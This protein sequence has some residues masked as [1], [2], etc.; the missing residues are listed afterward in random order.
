MGYCA[1]NSRV[2]SL[3][4]RLFEVFQKFFR[5]TLAKRDYSESDFN[6][7]EAFCAC[8]SADAIRPL[9]PVRPTSSNFDAYLKILP[10]RISS[11]L[12]SAIA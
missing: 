9:R 12:S 10:R 3:V 2:G 7:R 5:V 4:I 6:F 8:I 1:G 11:R